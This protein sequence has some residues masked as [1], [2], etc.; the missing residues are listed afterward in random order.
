MKMKTSILFG[1]FVAGLL[2]LMAIPMVML[3]ALNMGG[4]EWYWARTGNVLTDWS[5]WYLD[6]LPFYIIA[7]ATAFIS[8][9][10]FAFRI[11]KNEIFFWLFAWAFY[12]WAW[13]AIVGTIQPGWNWESS[14]YFDIWFHPTPM[15]LFLVA[16]IAGLGMGIYEMRAAKKPVQ[17]LPFVLWLIW[18]Y[19]MGAVTQ[20]IQVP[21][22]AWAIY[23]IIMVIAITAA[24]K[25]TLW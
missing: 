22:T 11:A 8:R 19:G 12:D 3:L 18:V 25:I 23:D 13:Q 17:L 5:I 15:W 6:V 2:I 21:W 9:K 7:F 10:H 14:F 4:P 24:F 20:V 16:A 1:A